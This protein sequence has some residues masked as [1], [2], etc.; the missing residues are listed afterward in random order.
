VH[1]QV[2]Q[3]KRRPLMLQAITDPR[4]ARLPGGGRMNE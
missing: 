1:R 4:H 3:P 2:D